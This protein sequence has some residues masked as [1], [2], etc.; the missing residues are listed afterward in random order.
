MIRL[1]PF[2]VLLAACGVDGPPLRP[3]PEATTKGTKITGETY[4]GWSR[5]D[6]F[7]QRVEMDLHMGG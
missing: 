7:K 2:L 4:F 3:E 6:G 1:L 5:K